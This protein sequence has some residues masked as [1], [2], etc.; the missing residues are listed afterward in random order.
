MNRNHRSFAALL[1]ACALSVLAACG[2]GGG[3]SSAPSAPSTPPVSPTNTVTVN[4][5]STSA[6]AVG[7]TLTLTWS[8]TNNVACVGAGLLQ[9][10]TAPSGTIQIPL[11]TVESTSYNVTCGGV[12]SNTVQLDI[13]PQYTVITDPVFEAAL[14]Q[15]GI[16][17]VIDGQVKT[18]SILAVTKL[19]ILSGTGYPQASD[20]KVATT[21]NAMITDL[22]GLSNFRNLSYLRLE[23]QGFTSIDVSKF[24]TLALLSV[25]QAPIT[26]IDL[27]H[28]PQLSTLGISETSLTSVDVSKL[29]SLQE[30]D[31]QNAG[32][33]PHVISTGANVQ[34]LTVLDVS[35]N[36]MLQRLY[37]SYNRLTAE[38]LTP[39]EAITDLWVDNNLMTS[40]KIGA[41]VSHLY[42]FGNPGLVT[43]Y[44]QSTQL[45]NA[46]CT[47]ANHCEIDPTTT[48]VQGQ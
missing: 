29:I 33:V 15:A 42:T 47:A 11:T 36:I 26:S 7:D 10:V 2:G 4:T 34:G 35:K 39:N 41:N 6:A 25:Y 9:G 5:L 3:S 32:P 14:V 12:I 38:D 21:G 24:A 23:G 22:T 43:L 27:S 13:L 8:N 1:A 30:I 20:V 16:D 18:S 19:A 46:T 48:I 28:N 17:D 45:S 44:T 40:L 31:A 37:A